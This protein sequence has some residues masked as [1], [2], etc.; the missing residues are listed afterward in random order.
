MKQHTEPHE[1]LASLWL[2]RRE[3]CV[4]W[5][6]IQPAVAIAWPLSRTA[7]VDCCLSA[8][9]WWAEGGFPTEPG[10][11]P[12]SLW[13]VVGVEDKW[14]S[15]RE[16]GGGGGSGGGGGGKALTIIIKVAGPMKLQM[17]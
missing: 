1:A 6:M 2:L 5:A 14:I 15:D 7:A 4:G 13:G 10:R 3:P 12:Q 16:K 11:A 9:L 17:K 8:P